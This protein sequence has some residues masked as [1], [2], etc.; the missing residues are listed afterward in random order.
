LELAE[1]GPDRQADEFW[2]CI[3]AADR[4]RVRGPMTR[5]EKG[6]SAF[7]VVV[8]VRRRDDAEAWLRVAAV[9]DPGDTVW[10]GTAE[11]LIAHVAEDVAAGSLGTDVG[12]VIHDIWQYGVD[13]V[14][15]SE[16]SLARASVAES[17]LESRSALLANMSHELRSPLNAILG[18]A[19][20]LRSGS[21]GPLPTRYAEY[22]QDIHRSGSFLLDVIDKV[23]DLAKLE[24]GHVEPSQATVGLG[25]LIREIERIVAPS[26]DANGNRFVVAGSSSR[27]LVT[28]ETRLRQC[29]INLI[30][31]AA[32]FTHHGEVRLRVEPLQQ[33][34]KSM[35]GFHVDDT[36]IGMT[37]EQVKNL[38]QPFR[39]AD[40]NVARTYGGTGL[41]LAIT[42]QLARLL[43]GD[44]TVRSVPGK[45]STFTLALP[46]PDAEAPARGPTR[47]PGDLVI[48]V[49]TFTTS[50]DPHLENR[51]DNHQILRHLFDT[52]VRFDD[53]GRLLPSI[54]TSW[55]PL[56][57]RTWEFRLRSD[58]RFHDGTPLLAQDVLATIER[59]RR[60]RVTSNP[61]AVFVGAIAGGEAIDRHTVRFRTRWPHSQLANDLAQ[62]FVLPA[63]TCDR[64]TEEFERLG[65][66][67]SGPYRYAAWQRGEFLRLLANGDYWDGRPRWPEVTWRAMLDSDD[68]AR[69]L[70]AGDVDIF[71][72][73]RH[74]E[75]ERLGRIPGTA[76]A[77]APVNALRFLQYDVRPAAN[78]YLRHKDGR[79]IERNPFVD[80]RVR[81]AMSM[82]VDRKFL[83]DFAMAGLGRSTGD[84]VI[85]GSFGANPSLMVEPFRPVEAR[86][87]L[88]AAG[89]GDGFEVVVFGLEDYDRTSRDLQRALGLMLSGI[90]IVTRFENLPRAPFFE[91]LAACDFAMALRSWNSLT[92]DASY[93][94]RH[95]LATPNA[96]EGFGGAN[97]GRYS[98]PEMDALLR[99]ALALRDDAV[100]EP[101]LRH[102]TKLAVDDLAIV[103][104]VTDLRTWVT[105]A[106]FRYRPAPSGYTSIHDVMPAEPANP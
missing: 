101:I 73:M 2:A 45:G 37:P 38:F 97:Y 96:E 23:L 15:R 40:R 104:L 78:A 42:R 34:G 55:Q 19:D 94:L 28:D 54:A 48:A 10:R 29:L 11:P 1:V 47:R 88:R 3:A 50:I 105:R 21:F 89:F 56:D 59:V 5:P 61:Y 24:A 8:R 103:P 6:M 31:N 79:P 91:R 27:T 85:P 69:A 72:V 60:M 16:R 86:G 80:W 95:L 41:G 4:D 106:G 65:P 77:Q 46:D 39:Q 51:L 43:G 90:G 98:N 100:R 18:F 92:G 13:L 30:G 63:A 93:T 67:G 7:D 49:A 70:A 102:A 57:D 33:S 66:I 17:A 53:G 76:L 81:K 68:R 32:K 14:E 22:A 25:D 26:M 99:R 84:I 52:L 87:L 62:I 12:R 71:R 82:A 83:A 9:T 75:L 58:I 35:L 36:G 44:V 20:V 74:A 64:T